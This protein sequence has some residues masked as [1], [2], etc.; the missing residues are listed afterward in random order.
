MVFLMFHFLVV[1]DK[2]T[3]NSV[4]T[5]FLEES[6]TSSQKSSPRAWWYEATIMSTILS[7]LIFMQSLLNIGFRLTLRWHNR[8]CVTSL[9]RHK[10]WP[11]LMLPILMNIV[12]LKPQVK[13]LKLSLFWASLKKNIGTFERNLIIF[14]KM[15]DY[16]HKTLV[17]LH[18]LPIANRLWE[19]ITMDFI[20]EIRA[21]FC[22]YNGIWTIVNQFNEHA[23][24]NL[25]CKTPKVDHTVT[26]FFSNIC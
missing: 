3:K 17:L 18:R 25:A 23:H 12:A 6:K 26:A 2:S 5:S 13:D 21:I 10:F 24:F 15:K 16:Q 8:L 19:S 22:G 14:Q 11:S 9:S 7:L 1:Y 20:F 4:A